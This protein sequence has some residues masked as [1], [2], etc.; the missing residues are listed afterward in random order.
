ML[1]NADLC[2]HESLQRTTATIAHEISHFWFG[3]LVTPTWWNF[4]WLNEGFARY[5]QFYLTNEV[6]QTHRI[7]VIVVSF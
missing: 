3:D 5:F 7:G 4:L 2:S 6:R 1:Y